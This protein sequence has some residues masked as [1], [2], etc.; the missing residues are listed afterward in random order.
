MMIIYMQY[1]LLFPMIDKIEVKIHWHNFSMV[2]KKTTFGRNLNINR[3]KLHS[4]AFVEHEV[5]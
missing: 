3:M 5:R 2:E 4:P 1:L